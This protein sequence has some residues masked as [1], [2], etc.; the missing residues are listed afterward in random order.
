MLNPNEDTEWNDVLR[1]KGII[2]DKPKKEAELTE[3]D[4]VN[5]IEQS[6]KERVEGKAL[7]DRD[8]DELDEL[9]D[10]E[11]DRVLE[12]YRRQR[13][14]E[15]QEQMK[16]EKFGEL[17]QISEPD[18]VREV[19]DAS[20]NVWVICHLFKDSIPACK[21]FNSLLSRLAAKHRYAKFVKI[22]GDHCIHGYPDKNMPTLLIYG[23]GD[24]KKQIVGINSFPGGMS[25][26]V[27]GVL[28]RDS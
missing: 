17:V 12:Q 3:D 1:A 9:E 19:S 6:I 13:M 20:K 8:L 27:D 22:V 2:P 25:C 15:M 7:E 26:T 11:D 16:R 23:H 5:M 28:S 24:M 10:L 4:I 21:L 14:A 18:F